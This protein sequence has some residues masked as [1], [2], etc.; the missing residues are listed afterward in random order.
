MTLAG[1][2]LDLVTGSAAICTDE[3]RHADYALQMAR[4][5]AGD[6]VSVPVDKE[7]L[8]L[9]WRKEVGLEDFDR[10]I[11]HVAAISET[12]SCG[13]ISACLERATD[14]TTR[15]LFGN[16]VSD[17]IH[18][19]RFG[20]YYLAWRAPQWSPAERQRIADRVARN[21]VTIEQR[22]WEGRDAPATARD[23]ARALGVLESEDQRDVVREVMEEEIVPA[24]DALGLGG[25]H[26]WRLRDRGRPR[27]AR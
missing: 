4:A 18:H 9:P 24:L 16:L 7:P 6:D 25:S 8:E 1:L 23:A 19:A 12:L 2:P 13:L 10:V 15:V 27:A 22:F 26:A 17:E 14:E 5:V 3:A 21:V 20:W 11:V